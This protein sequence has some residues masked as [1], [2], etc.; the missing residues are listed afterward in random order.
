MSTS[1]RDIES[2]QFP[3][4]IEKPIDASKFTSHSKNTF[5]RKTN[6]NGH[7]LP[8]TLAFIS[9]HDENQQRGADQQT[10]VNPEGSSSS[11]ST[12]SASIPPLDSLVVRLAQG[13]LAAYV[14]QNSSALTF[15]EKV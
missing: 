14:K 10:I 11:F 7:N 9:Q 15:P 1:Q 5:I 3:C 2:E 8:S 6:K 12:T 4:S 13:D